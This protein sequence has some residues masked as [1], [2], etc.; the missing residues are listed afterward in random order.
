[1]FLYA[2]ACLLYNKLPM[3]PTLHRFLLKEVH[4]IQTQASVPTCNNSMII[5]FVNSF[6]KPW[7]APVKTHSGLVYMSESIALTTW[8]VPK[9]FRLSY[10]IYTCVSA[11]SSQI[12]TPLAWQKE[13]VTKDPAGIARRHITPSSSELVL[14]FPRVQN[15][16]TWRGNKFMVLC[17]IFGL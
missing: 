5:I 3:L 9:F 1:M 13:I 14:F 15:E 16:D 12:S 8:K 6:V 17:T 2:D 4:F 11:C 7:H 10:L